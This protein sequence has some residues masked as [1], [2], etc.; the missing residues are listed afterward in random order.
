V[1]RLHDNLDLLV[2][3][4]FLFF[5]PFISMLVICILEGSCQLHLFEN[6]SKV[7]FVDVNLDPAVNDPGP[8]FRDKFGAELY[9]FFNANSICRDGEVLFENLLY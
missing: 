3:Y 2:L 7:C 8:S 6:M 1:I 9:H 5:L 4:I